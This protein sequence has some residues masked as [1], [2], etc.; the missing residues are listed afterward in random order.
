MISNRSPVCYRNV[1]CSIRKRRSFSSESWPGSWCSCWS[2]TWFSS[3]ASCWSWRAPAAASRGW[4]AARESRPSPSCP[5]LSSSA[6]WSLSARRWL[7]SWGWRGSSAW[8]PPGWR[9]W[10]PS[11]CPWSHRTHRPW[12]RWRHGSWDP[13]WWRCHRASSWWPLRRIF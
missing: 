4:G 2:W 1:R 3:A 6:S 13:P 5:P 8:P 7:S 10:C 12:T 9:C 11:Q